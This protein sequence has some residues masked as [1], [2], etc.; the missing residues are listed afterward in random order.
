MGM[1]AKHELPNRVAAHLPLD[2]RIPSVPE[3]QL[4]E[5]VT[6]RS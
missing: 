3:S 4:D 2:H 1:H 6:R 5:S